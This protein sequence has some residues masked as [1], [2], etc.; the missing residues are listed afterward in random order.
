[1]NIDRPKKKSHAVQ[2]TQ[3]ERMTVFLVIRPCLVY[4]RYIEKVRAKDTLVKVKELQ[5]TIVHITHLDN[6]L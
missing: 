5:I 2:C 3:L 6:H 4:T 1:M